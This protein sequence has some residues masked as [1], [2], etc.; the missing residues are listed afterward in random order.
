MDCGVSLIGWRKI[1]CQLF[2][3]ITIAIDGFFVSG[4]FNGISAAAKHLPENLK[5][6]VF[7]DAPGL[8]IKEFSFIMDLKRQNPLLCVIIASENLEGYEVFEALASGADGWI[9]KPISRSMIMATF[10][11]LK[12]G[13][14][15]LCSEVAKLLVNS[16]KRN[17][18][19]PLSKRETQVLRLLARGMTYNAIA[20]NLYINRET[21]K[22]HIKNIYSKLDVGSKAEAL[23]KAAEEKLI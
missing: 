10:E 3:D 18:Y 19:S 2:G 14:A 9:C 6:I 8:G 23:Q 16:F 13:G 4:C 17:P 15:P 5:H 7:I 12:N 22:S 20:D 11:E 21:A 1:D